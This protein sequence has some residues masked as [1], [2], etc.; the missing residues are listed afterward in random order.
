[1]SASGCVS[2]CVA[3]SASR[4]AIWWF[5]SP[6]M[7]TAARVVAANAA[8][9]T[10]GAVSLLGAQ[11]CDNLLSSGI[12]VALS[13][14]M[15]ECRAG[16]WPGSDASPRGG[17]ERA[18]ERR[19]HHGLP[20]CRT[21]ARLLGST[22]A[23]QSA[24]RIGMPGTGPDQVLVSSGQ[25]LDRLGLCAVARQ[26]AVIVPV[27]ADQIGEQLG[28]TGIGFRAGDLMAVAVAGPPQISTA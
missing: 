16:P 11:R 21:P 14:R 25:D 23:G 10:V 19:R 8:V 13:P 7:L 5:S 20:G 18:P 6:M 4:S 1:M 28:V 24:Q 26:R 27:G 9:I 22:R 12:D 15:F 17:W 3:S 2:K